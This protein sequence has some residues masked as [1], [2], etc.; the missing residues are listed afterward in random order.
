PHSE[1]R[2]RGRFSGV[3]GPFEPPSV[4]PVAGMSDGGASLYG[5][6]AVISRG[7]LIRLL[8]RG[9]LPARRSRTVVRPSP[10]VNIQGLMM[11]RARH[12]AYRVSCRGVWPELG[13]RHRQ[14]DG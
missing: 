6:V 13:G 2:P 12:V 8:R 10:I 11:L 3:P 14:P 1:N 5:S 4:T 9:M 7:G